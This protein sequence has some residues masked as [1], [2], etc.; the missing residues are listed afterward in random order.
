MGL[1]RVG[2]SRRRGGVRGLVNFVGCCRKRKGAC[3][4][5][6]GEAPLVLSC[7]CTGDLVLAAYWWLR[8]WRSHGCGQPELPANTTEQYHRRVSL[9]CIAVEYY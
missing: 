5:H 3:A 2:L 1:L 7:R 9:A 6:K 4:T 8:W